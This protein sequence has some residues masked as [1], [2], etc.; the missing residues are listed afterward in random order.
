M[1]WKFLDIS[2]LRDV[3]LFAGISDRALESLLAITTTLHPKPAEL[4]FREGDAG[5]AL[6]IILDGEVRISK[7]IHGVGEEALAFLKAGSYFGEMA[8]LDE[9]ARRS[10]HA[11][12]GGTCHL[13]VL[14]RDALLKLMRDDR[15]LANEILWSFV[16]TLSARLRESNEKI[17]FF[18][19]SNMFE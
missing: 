10:A 7:D 18:A 3:D 19:M 17:A 4:I 16:A 12:A 15:D 1:S 13:G 2:T 14:E 11:I 5:N 6:Y 8:L 9:H